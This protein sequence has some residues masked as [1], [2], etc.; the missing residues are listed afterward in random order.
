MTY[1]PRG[2]D[3][4]LSQGALGVTIFF[5]LSGFL[6]TCSH[7]KDFT[8]QRLPTIPYYRNFLLKRFAR[9]Y[10]VY[11][12]GLVLTLSSS[13]M[14][15][16]VPVGLSTL[17]ILNI[18]M[19][20]SWFPTL[21]MQW[22]GSG[23]W[24]ISTEV[25]FYLVFP[26]ALP[27]FLRIKHRTTLFLALGALVIVAAAPGL[28]HNF[29][30]GDPSVWGFQITYPFP[31]ARLSEFL[32]GILTGLL[33]LRFN[34]RVPVLIML[35]LLV[36]GTIYLA[37]TGF[38]LQGYVAHNWIMLPVIVSVVACLASD[39]QNFIL[40]W[41][42]APWMGYLGR[43]SYSFYILQLAILVVFDTLSKRGVVQPDALWVMPILLLFNLILAAVMYEF[44]EKRMHK[45][46]LAWLMPARKLQPNVLEESPS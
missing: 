23:S 30:F 45:M 13:I 12:A 35:G 43:I 6:L 34:W 14:L 44:L 22:Y 18:T 33:V 31:P 21:A 20:H 11:F 16:D 3:A 9:I 42:G 38:R 8:F 1:L 19:L 24:S 4:I 32:I 7:L 46:V 26:L 40:R 10:P 27:L 37:L 17:L 25:F 15:N 29:A 5:V 36:V 28:L 39:P 2:L 41:L